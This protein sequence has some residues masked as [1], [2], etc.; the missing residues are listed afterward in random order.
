MNQVKYEIRRIRNFPEDDID[1]I[2]EVCY[3]SQE[4]IAT[5]MHYQQSFDDYIFLHKGR[6]S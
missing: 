5:L 1:N 6:T 4:A 3:D 2:V